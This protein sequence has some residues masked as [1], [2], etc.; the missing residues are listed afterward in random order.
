MPEGGARSSLAERGNGVAVGEEEGNGVRVADAGDGVRV[1]GEGVR[2][3]GEPEPGGDDTTAAA[4]ALELGAPGL[5][6]KGP[7]CSGGAM[8]SEPASSAA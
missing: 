1:A 3:A 5:G 6:A 8:G 4:T 7:T 2:V